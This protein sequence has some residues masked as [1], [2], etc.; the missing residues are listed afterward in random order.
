MTYKLSHDL[1]VLLLSLS[2]VLLEE[3]LIWL[4]GPGG[5]RSGGSSSV[6]HGESTGRRDQRQKPEKI[7]PV[8]GGDTGNWIDDDQSWG[9]D[10]EML[11]G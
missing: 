10:K 3:R 2:E 8:S 7:G 9:K 1:L 11:R 5:R 4:G 6:S